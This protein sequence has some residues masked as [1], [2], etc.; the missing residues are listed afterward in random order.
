[1]ASYQEVL[2][3]NGKIIS[4]IRRNSCGIIEVYNID[5]GITSYIRKGVL[6]CKKDKDMKFIYPKPSA[7]PATEEQLKAYLK[8]INL[9]NN[10]NN[11]CGKSS[12]SSII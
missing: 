9:I 7:P 5:S 3:N 12:S 10:C 6:L 8:N 2:D 11:T 1:M 4:I